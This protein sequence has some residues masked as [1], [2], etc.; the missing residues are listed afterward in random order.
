MVSTFL[1]MTGM[2]SQVLLPVLSSVL[3]ASVPFMCM[4]VCMRR[5]T[6]PASGACTEYYF[7]VDGVRY[8]RTYNLKTFGLGDC[9]E[10]YNDND[11][12]VICGDLECEGDETI[13]NCWYFLDT[14]F[15]RYRDVRSNLTWVMVPPSSDCGPCSA[16]QTECNAL[17]EQCEDVCGNGHCGPLEVDMTV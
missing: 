9:T 12:V 15:V 7:M 13:L 1:T 4:R 2:S 16:P 11:A 10:E 6:I 3:N 17:T 5:Q 14:C 8:P